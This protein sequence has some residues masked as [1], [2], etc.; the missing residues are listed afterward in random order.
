MTTTK[1]TKAEVRADAEGVVSLRQATDFPKGQEVQYGTYW[2]GTLP[3][4][5]KQEQREGDAFPS[6][7]DADEIRMRPPQGTIHLGP[8]TFHR[9]I[10]PIVRR[11]RAT[12]AQE[13][14]RYYGSVQVLHTEQVKSVIDYAD[15]GWV[16]WIQRRGTRKDWGRIFFEPTPAQVEA[17]KAA[18][19]AR[20]EVWIPSMTPQPGDE[21]IGKFVYML[22]IADGTPYPP[23][24]DEPNETL[25]DSVRGLP[26]SILDAG[27]ALP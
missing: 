22:K 2:L 1:K 5:V 17:E 23:M 26:P 12:G 16:R 20:K 15:R 19:E 21:R 25:S 11:A 24:V 8:A 14:A 27:I 9:W 10:R 18:A 7:V 6:E 13:R 4:G 3:V